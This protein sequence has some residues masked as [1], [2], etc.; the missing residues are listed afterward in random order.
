MKA[1]SWRSTAAVPVALLVLCGAAQAQS[2]GR[3]DMTPGYVN[4]K[5]AQETARDSE[6]EED[7]DRAAKELDESRPEKAVN[8]DTERELRELKASQSK[9]RSQVDRARKQ[10]EQAK[11][12]AMKEM[13]R[14][15]KEADL[16]R[17]KARQSLD[18]ALST[19]PKGK[20]MPE[21]AFS[22]RDM[23][24]LKKQMDELQR[25]LKSSLGDVLGEREG[26]GAD[27]FRGH[28]EALRDAQ[29]ALEQVQRELEDASRN[30]KLDPMARGDALPGAQLSMSDL[31][32]KSRDAMANAMKAM[33]RLKDLMAEMPR[34][35]MPPTP[36][37]P[38]PR[39]FSSRS[40]VFGPRAGDSV[41]VNGNNL[42]IVRGDTVYLL[43]A[44]TLEVKRTQ[45]LPGGLS[46]GARESR[47]PA[48]F[49]SR[50]STAAPNSGSRR[51]RP[52]DPSVPPGPP[53]AG[54]SEP[55]DPGDVVVP[56]TSPAPPKAEPAPAT[57]AA[58]EAVEPP[59]PAP[60]SEPAPA[61][62]AAPEPAEPPA[63]TPASEPEAK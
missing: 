45:R 28:E 61:T 53:S 60:A 48:A 3:P 22:G 10:A 33:P 17:M 63:P 11:A 51:T 54:V 25:D 5:P 42:Y 41:A 21:D 18:S 47:P 9:L 34:P 29:R 30:M 38:S 43:D 56:G 58:P 32:G 4:E 2:P 57:P 52:M 7:L 24:R 20:P 26:M 15:R 50:G 1:T 19:W 55:A 13:S 59:A 31:M 6:V 23:D 35:A 14:A 27:A 12:Q 36:S 62:P 44:N 8:Q 46:T 16:A 40:D 49:R 37:L 39:S